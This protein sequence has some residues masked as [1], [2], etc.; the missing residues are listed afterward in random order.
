MS[1]VG[2]PTTST[3][4]WSGS[5]ANDDPAACYPAGVLAFNLAY[6]SIAS[7]YE[8]SALGAVTFTE[9][10]GIPRG[11]GIALVTVCALAGFGVATRI[12]RR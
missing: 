3:A 11:A 9:L 2:A 5:L 12:E 8:G 7:F 10:L 4:E 1:T 6:D